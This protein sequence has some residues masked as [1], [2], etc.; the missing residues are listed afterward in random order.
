MASSMHATVH[1]GCDAVELVSDS[2]YG[3][4][5]NGWLNGWVRKGW[6]K[7]M[8]TQWPIEMSGSGTFK[9]YPEFREGSRPHTSR[10]H[11]P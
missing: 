11:K 3:G 5:V 1:A 6:R 8:A 2:R 4:A 9:D 7:S 10:S